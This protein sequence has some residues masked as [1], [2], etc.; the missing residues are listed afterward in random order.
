MCSPKREMCFRHSRL[1]NCA[2]SLL[3]IKQYA[4]PLQSIF[5]ILPGSKHQW[6]YDNFYG[7]TK[8]LYIAR[9]EVFTAIDAENSSVVGCDV[10]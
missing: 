4:T 7:Y 9:F 5:V 3:N 1:I 6:T 10:M 2:S 8:Q